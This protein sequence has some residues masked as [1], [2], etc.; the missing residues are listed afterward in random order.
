MFTARYGLVFIYNSTFC[1]HSVFMCFVWIWEQTAIISL[2]SINWLVFITERECVYCVVRARCFS[3]FRIHCSFL[4]RT[5]AE[6]VSRRPHTVEAQFRSQVSTCEICGGQFSSWIEAS[7]SSC[8]FPLSVSSL[9]YTIFFII[10][11]LLLPEWQTGKAWE[12]F[13]MKS[14][15]GIGEHWIEMYSLWVFKVLILAMLNLWRVLSDCYV[16]MC[17]FSVYKCT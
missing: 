11:T 5:I 15:L 8:V 9:Q 4:E 10:Y 6:A 2:Y 7:P 16:R 12:P 13:K 3:T 14:V 17:Y 1:P